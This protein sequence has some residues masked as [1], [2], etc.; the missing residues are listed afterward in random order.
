MR[1]AVP[2]FEGRISPVFDWAQRLLVIDHDGTNE[3]ARS[4]ENLAGLAPPFRPGR[5]AHLGVEVLLCGGISAPVAAMLESQGVSVIPGL[6]GEV[7]GVF[8]AFF[9]GRLPDPA[10]AMPGWRCYGQGRMG[11]GGGRRWRR[12]GR[13]ER[14]GG[15][16]RGRGGRG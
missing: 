13:K 9:A 16:G 1:V 11:T 5:L 7:D 2:I 3:Q 6:V 8:E 15:R 14:R 10:F 12:G 4:E